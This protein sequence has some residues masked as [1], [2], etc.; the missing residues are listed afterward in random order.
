MN[1]DAL[2]WSKHLDESTEEE[3]EKQCEDNEVREMKTTAQ[4]AQYWAMKS[5]HIYIMYIL[6]TTEWKSN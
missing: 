3:N 4:W 1:A 5:F 2:S 6:I